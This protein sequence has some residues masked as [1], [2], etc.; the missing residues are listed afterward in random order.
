MLQSST[1]KKI[2]GLWGANLD[3]EISFDQKK[4]PWF[5]LEKLNTTNIMDFQYGAFNET[6]HPWNDVQDENDEEMNENDNENENE[7]EEKKIE[8]E[9]IE[10]TPKK[11][12]KQLSEK[13][14]W[15]ASDLI[16]TICVHINVFTSQHKIFSHP[17]DFDDD[18][19][20]EADDVKYND[21]DNKDDENIGLVT[22]VIN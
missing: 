1:I 12:K 4:H 10:D 22:L 11:N 8:S 9:D 21:D 13:R 6:F 20:D 5:F 15:R 17:M 14:Q 19:H 2:Q 18:H 7:E 16:P 3:K